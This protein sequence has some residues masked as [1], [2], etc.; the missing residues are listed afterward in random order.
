MGREAG[1]I[2]AT[3]LKEEQGWE[4]KDGAFWDEQGVNLEQKWAGALEFSF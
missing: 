1:N 3:S 4:G 2:P